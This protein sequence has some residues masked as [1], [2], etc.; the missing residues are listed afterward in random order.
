M[1]ANA[2]YN[3]VLIGNNFA[4]G[5]SGITY[6]QDRGNW[7]CTMPPGAYGS[8][9]TFPANVA[10]VANTTVQNTYGVSIQISTYVTVSSTSTVSLWI[11][12]TSGTLHNSGKVAF[13]CTGNLTSQLFSIVPPGWYYNIASSG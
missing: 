12:A 6:G 3:K 10:I 11:G 2:Y 1:M 13:T 5:V 8:T 9:P 7:V 4:G